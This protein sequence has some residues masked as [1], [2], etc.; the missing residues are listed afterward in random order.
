MTRLVTTLQR[1]GI[2]E[3]AK[4]LG[5]KTGARELL[6]QW[7]DT[8][9]E[10]VHLR[11]F[12]GAN[13]RQT[14]ASTIRARRSKHRGNKSSLT[15]T[16]ID[17]YQLLRVSSKNGRG[18]E[19]KLDV[20]KMEARVGVDRSTTYRDPRRGGRKKK[21]NRESVTLSYLF[22]RHAETGRAILVEPSAIVRRKMSQQ[23]ADWVKKQQ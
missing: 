5:K 22:Q 16:L 17:T 20:P 23:A 9:F 14:L 15:R 1:D 10:Y 6:G 3:F 21:G 18:Q 2:Q 19:R 11:H 13:W 4:S 8:Y 7:A 12:K